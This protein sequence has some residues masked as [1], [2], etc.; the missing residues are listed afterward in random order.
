MTGLRLWSLLRSVSGVVVGGMLINA[1]AFG[2]FGQADCGCGG[3]SMRAVAPISMMA[4]APAYQ[5]PTPTAYAPISAA[6]YNAPGCYC[7]TPQ[8]PPVATTIAITPLAQLQPVTKAEVREVQVMKHRAVTKTVSRPTMKVRY[9][10]SP[11]TA[12]RQVA[13][14]KTVEVPHTM[15]QNVTEMKQVVSNKSQWKT[16]M[17]PIPKMTAQQYDCRPG[18]LGAMNRASYSTRQAFTPSYIP[19]REFVPQV[20]VCNVPQQ[21]T[22]AVP[23]K[24]TVAYNTTRLEPYQT[25]QRVAEQYMDNEQ[26]QVTTYEPYYETEKRTAMV[27][28]YVVAP[29]GAGGSAVA[30]GAEPTPAKT[31]D[32]KLNDKST[33]GT[34]QLQSYPGPRSSNSER[35]A[36]S[37]PEFHSAEPPVAQQF[38]EPTPGPSVVQ[39]TGWKA[40]RGKKEDDR[41]HKAGN[42]SSLA[43]AAK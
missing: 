36:N 21:K 19:R 26:V 18:L 10:E 42:G 41:S 6:A 9:V 17:Q 37:K 13:E 29:I 30:N 1:P 43:I 4:A 28:S 3:P 27:T 11:V 33:N 22:V 5:C 14:T 25:T 20:C 39:V 15:Y 34:F 2:Q 31:A 38:A 32:Q 23:A 7:Y 35:P 16:V 12:Y 8:P 40:Y 24:R